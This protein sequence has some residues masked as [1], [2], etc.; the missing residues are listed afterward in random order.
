MSLSSTTTTPSTSRNW[1]QGRESYS[2]AS[3]PK[4]NEEQADKPKKVDLS[5][6]AHCHQL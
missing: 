3:E 1:V 5:A 4:K 2:T 6:C